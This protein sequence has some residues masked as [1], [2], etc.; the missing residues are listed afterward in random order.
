MKQEHV[1]DVSPPM[2]KKKEICVSCWRI[3]VL[4]DRLVSCWVELDEAALKCFHFW[5]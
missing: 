4:S 1:T 2:T 5:F 3:V